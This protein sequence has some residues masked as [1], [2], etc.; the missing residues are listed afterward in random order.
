MLMPLAPGK[1]LIDP[2]KMI[3]KIDRLPPALQKWD[4]IIV[5]EKCKPSEGLSLA[6]TSIYTN[7]LPLG[8]NKVLIF[9][10]NKDPNFALEKLL[11]KHD[12]E[13][14]HVRLRHSRLFSGGNHCVTLDLN[15]EETLE[16]YFS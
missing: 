4:R 15:R 13:V 3:S 6:S 10:E 12:F 14:I 2:D 1:L 11:E 16:D 7:V 8:P 5:P 9:S